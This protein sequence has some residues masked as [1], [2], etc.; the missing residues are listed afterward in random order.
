M[1][2]VDDEQVELATPSGPM[3]THIFKPAASGK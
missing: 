2:V 1:I 3:R